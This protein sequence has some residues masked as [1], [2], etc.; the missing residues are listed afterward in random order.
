[1]IDHDG[2]RARETDEQAQ[3][4][5]YKHDREDDADDRRGEAKLVVKEVARGQFQNQ[6]HGHCN[7]L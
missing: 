1:M 4:H 2:H 7:T 5:G 6:R 3:L